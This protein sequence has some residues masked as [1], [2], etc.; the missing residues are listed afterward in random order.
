MAR[1]Y[2]YEQ[3]GELNR[4]LKKAINPDTLKALHRKNPWHHFFIAGRQLS[5]FVILPLIIFYFQHPLIWVPA[6]ILMGF[7]IFGFT[8]LLHEA[9]HKC[10][11]NKDPHNLSRKLAI[12]YGTL[13]GL[14]ASQFH[15]WHID[16]HNQLGSHTKDPKRAHLSP[17]RNARWYKF[18]YCTPLLFPIYMR[19]SA[20]E[21]QNYTEALRRKIKRER[22]A[23]VIF[24]LA[25]IAFMW[26]LS[27]WF[28]LKAW[29]IPQFIIFPMAFTL[30]RLGQHYI[31]NPDDV[32]N[33]STL[34]RP[35]P[36]WNFLFLFSSYHLEHHYYPGVPFYK[37]KALQKELDPFYKRRGIPTYTYG[38][39]LKL[40][41]INNH[42]PHTR[43]R[44]ETVEQQ[45]T[46]FPKPV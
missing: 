30:N 34:M 32:A 41:F 13:C 29:I 46:G 20:R 15:R 18:L 36:V 1:L 12:L 19:A 7:V 42:K 21:Q 40:W 31:I 5:L 14:S 39:L 38:K 44:E 28:A 23:S 27:P 26:W 35:N 4:E 25:V 16:H 10:I 45:P 17:K 11:F 2:Y 24:V 6:S 43:P 3:A 22:M 37:L 8:I 33:W 9:I